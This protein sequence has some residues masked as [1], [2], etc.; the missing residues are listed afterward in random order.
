MMVACL[1]RQDLIRIVSDQ[2]VRFH[3]NEFD[4]TPY[5]LDS[6]QN[7]RPFPT[8]PYGRKSSMISQTW[9]EGLTEEMEVME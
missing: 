6:I 7:L 9:I 2:L 3:K 1:P 4:E 8:Q 5:N